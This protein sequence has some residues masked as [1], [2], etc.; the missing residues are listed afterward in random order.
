MRTIS[1]TLVSSEN[2]NNDL[3][4]ANNSVQ[5][6][7]LQVSFTFLK[8]TSMKY[9][10][11]Q[12]HKKLNMR[13][14]II[15]RTNGQ[16]RSQNKTTIYQV[17]FGSKLGFPKRWPIKKLLKKTINN[18]V[19]LL[20]ISKCNL[21]WKKYENAESFLMIRFLIRNENTTTL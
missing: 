18:L 14:K 11:Y 17:N 19:G 1:K 4:L 13:S 20:K 5:I 12:F 21:L 7:I 6:L 3:T 10:T 16:L 8:F 15:I 9:F 2:I